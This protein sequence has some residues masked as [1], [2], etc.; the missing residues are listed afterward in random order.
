MHTFTISYMC[1]CMHAFTHSCILFSIYRK[2]SL[3]VWSSSPD[4][5]KGEK[6]SHISFIFYLIFSLHTFKMHDNFI[7][8]NLTELLMRIGQLTLNDL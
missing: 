3:N 2:E 8:E 7:D 5:M 1:E 6:N 4:N